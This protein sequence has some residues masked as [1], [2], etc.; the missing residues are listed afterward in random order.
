MA[1]ASSGNKPL[2]V[3][4]PSGAESLAKR[5]AD[6]A[7][8]SERL[9]QDRRALQVERNALLAQRSE[10]ELSRRQLTVDREHLRKI[11][12]EISRLVRTI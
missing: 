3:I 7:A 6:L 2:E 12:D 5:T 1:K 4:S 8:A 10:L 9:E 11:S